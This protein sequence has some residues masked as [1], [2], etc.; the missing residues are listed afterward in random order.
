MDSV[1]L[2]DVGEA[3]ENGGRGLL[4]REGV[5]SGHAECP[6]AEL[7]EP[8]FVCLAVHPLCGQSKLKQRAADR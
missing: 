6:S 4:G 1:E 3:G 2:L 8:L 7:S 5:L